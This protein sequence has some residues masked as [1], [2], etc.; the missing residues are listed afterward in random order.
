MAKDDF[1]PHSLTITR[2]GKQIARVISLVLYL[3]TGV[4]LAGAVQ[5]DEPAEP[6]LFNVYATDS[7]QPLIDHGL[8]MQEQERHEEAIT[9]LKQARQ[10]SRIQSGLYDE[11]Q[12][13]LLE[14]IIESEL[15]MEN[16][17]EVDNHYR[18]MEHLYN[19]LYDME[20]PRLETGLRKVSGWLSFSL[21][22]KPTGDRI[23]Q[24]YRASRIYKQRLEIARRTLSADHPKV[25]Y[26]QENIDI[27]EKQ[28]YPMP[29]NKRSSFRRDRGR[30][31]RNPILA[32][33]D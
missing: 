13:L 26:L 19:K 21:S 14:A 12:V 27:C 30:W 10:A 17:E 5:A 22:A 32:T 3:S 16:W 28:L 18:H 31:S 9:Y 23:D 24:L 33:I 8:A 2:H 25:A 4:L 6:R 11:T 29:S 20:D 15:A 1:Q 7:L